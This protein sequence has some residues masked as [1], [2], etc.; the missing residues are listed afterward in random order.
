MPK[1]QL[2]AKPG[3]NIFEMIQGGATYAGCNQG[4][5][6]PQEFIPKLLEAHQQGMFPYERMI[7]TYRARDIQ[8]A[9][10]DVEKGATIKAV[11]LW[12]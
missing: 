7:K 1:I 5:C 4:D 10:S 3:L 9:V 2:S 11:L 8:K 12:D 6:Y